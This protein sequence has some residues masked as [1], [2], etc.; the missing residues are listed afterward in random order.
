MSSRMHRPR[1]SDREIEV[2]L[3]WL[4]CETKERAAS[5]L[6]IRPSTV[7]T[8]LR[9]I[10]DKYREAGRP[11][12]TKIELLVRAVEDG[13]ITLDDVTSRVNAR[14]SGASAAAHSELTR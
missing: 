1:L 4:C 14:L 9:R 5:E 10:R 12:Y 8:H 7:N 13:H 2:L 11:A 3:R 6:F